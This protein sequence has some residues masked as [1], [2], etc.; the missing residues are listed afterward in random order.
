VTYV[1]NKFNLLKDPP[2]NFTSTIYSRYELCVLIEKIKMLLKR[3]KKNKARLFEK[4]EV[5]DESTP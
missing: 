5:Y 3:K 1:E 4:E 2:S